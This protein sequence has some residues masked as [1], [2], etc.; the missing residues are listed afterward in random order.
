VDEETVALTIRA[1]ASAIARPNL[2][3]VVV[4][5]HASPVKAPPHSGKA[6]LILK[7]PSETAFAS[8]S[9]WSLSF[10]LIGAIVGQNRKGSVTPKKLK[11]QVIT[12]FMV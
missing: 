8:A 11:K 2:A 3:V 12:F 7:N 9:I 10:T 4:K 1:A 5:E 6:A